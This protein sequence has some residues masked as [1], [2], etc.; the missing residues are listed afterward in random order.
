M[1]IT[2][3][4]FLFTFVNLYKTMKRKSTTAIANLAKRA[5]T[6]MRVRLAP[7]GRKSEVKVFGAGLPLSTTVSSSGTAYQISALAQGSDNGQRI[8]NKVMPLALR[9]N[10]NVIGATTDATSTVRFLL[11]RTKGAMTTTATDYIANYYSAPNHEAFEILF[12]RFV[13]LSSVNATAVTNGVAV[14]NKRIKLNKKK[15]VR[16]NGAAQNATVDNQI[17]MIVMSDSG[18]ANHPTIGGYYEFFYTDP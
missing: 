5:R 13:S 17:M 3:N 15:L 9:I 11:V 4:I 8:G 18:A 16:Y 14:V 7:I 10:F 1:T 12:D 6:H 2:F